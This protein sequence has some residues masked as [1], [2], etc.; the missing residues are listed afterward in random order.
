MLLQT[1][2]ELGCNDWQAGAGGDQGTCL[3]R[4][5]IAAANQQAGLVFQ[6]QE[7]WALIPGWA[8]SYVR[9]IY[10]SKDVPKNNDCFCLYSA[11]LYDMYRF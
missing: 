3:A 1:G 2:A 5:N 9:P 7:S 10:G 11:A 4:G 8:S 6:I